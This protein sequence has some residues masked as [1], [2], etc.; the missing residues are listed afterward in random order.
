[1]KQR[2]YILGLG[3]L[4]T[5]FLGALF[6]I[7]HWPAAGILLTV[8]LVT[9]VLAFIPLAI[10]NSYKASERKKPFLFFITWLTSFVI[11]TSMLFK[12][13]HWPYA[14]LMLFIALPFPYI[15]F[16]PVFI[17]SNSRDKNFNMGNLVAVLVLLAMNSVFAGMLALNVS[18]ERIYD[19]YNI[20]R[21]S[22][23]VGS[24]L[25]SNNQSVGRQ[26]VNNSIDNV[27]KVIDEYQAAV[28]KADENTI[29]LWRQDP[30]NLNRPDARGVASSGLVSAGE[31]EFGTRLAVS[32]QNLIDELSN[33]P[34]LQDLAKAVPDILGF[35]T[36]NGSH[37][38]WALENFSDCSLSWTMIYLQGLKTDLMTIKA[39]LL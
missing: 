6:K 13:M 39:S 14:G 12:L 23:T 19:S 21:N 28:L 11:F 9:L 4:L 36:E 34:E 17:A 26:P 10:T 24:V 20:A 27:I 1:M 33:E 18:R 15:V 25:S 7:N 30:D 22:I 38:K 32:I 31:K 5:I 16:L 35:R 2:I 3:T 29:E 8:G 37:L